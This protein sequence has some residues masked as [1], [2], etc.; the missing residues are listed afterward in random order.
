MRF[1]IIKALSVAL[2]VVSAASAQIN[3]PMDARQVG[4]AGGGTM[5]DFYDVYKWPALMFE[6]PNRISAT[7][8]GGVLGIYS[9]SDLFAVGVAANQGLMANMGIAI[10]RPAAGDDDD[11]DTMALVPSFAASAIN[12][13]DGLPNI[14]A[15]GY[16]L[17]H[18]DLWHTNIPHIL[19]G[20]NFGAVK[21]GADIFFEYARYS[22]F[23]K[24]NLFDVTQTDTYNGLMLNPG[25]RLS[26]DIDIGSLG[27]MAKAGLSLP[28]FKLTEE[29]SVTGEQTVTYTTKSDKGIYVELGTEL[30]LS[31]S[32]LDL[33]AGTEYAFTEH[34]IKDATTSYYNSYLSLY[35]GGEFSFLTAAKASAMYR[36]QRLAGTITTTNIVDNIAFIADEMVSIHYHTISAGMENVWEK[37]Y[38]FD[39]VAIRAGAI[40]GIANVVGDYSEIISL[41]TKDWKLFTQY[42]TVTPTMGVGVTKSFLTIDLYCNI[43]S[44]EGVFT[45]P[46]V[47]AA[48]A[49]IKF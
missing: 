14:V 37:A 18:P 12:T 30:S 20:L 36:F 7:W 38:F 32:D 29:H 49:T 10:I 26:V 1:S 15:N 39:N 44:W 2:V 34:S 8:G 43:G 24:Y 4:M 27:I 31:L 21:L 41:H 23:E 5:A 11:A 47:G 13:L 22:N 48:T 9:V 42:T 33:T 40:Y 28:S 25:A 35:A 3:S 46:A 45:G 19:L 17:D 16:T 6:Y